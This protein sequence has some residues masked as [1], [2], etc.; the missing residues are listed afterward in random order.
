MDI[1]ADGCDVS[2]LLSYGNPILNRICIEGP[3]RTWKNSVISQTGCIGDTMCSRVVTEVEPRAA[4]ELGPSDNRC[5]AC[6]RGGRGGDLHHWVRAT[7]LECLD[8][9]DCDADSLHEYA[10]RLR[11]SYHMRDEGGGVF[12]TSQKRCIRLHIADARSFF[13]PLPPYQRRF[14]LLSFSVS[15]ISTSEG[16]E[17]FFT[18][19]RD[20]C[21]VTDLL[22]IVH[23]HVWCDIPSGTDDGI[24]IVVENS[25]NQL[26]TTVQ[27]FTRW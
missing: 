23:D 26:R 11:Q 12:R 13:P 3:L 16:L 6:H 8:V 9:V 27:F 2:D 22:L 10:R 18:H 24:E 25:G 5:V 19:L 1:V 17:A 4:L 21:H 20:R 7:R 15:Q 14:A